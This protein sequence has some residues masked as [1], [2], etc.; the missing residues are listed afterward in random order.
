[1]KSISIPF[2]FESASGVVAT[3]SSRGKTQATIDNGVIAKQ[4]IADVL[5]TRKNERVMR[6][7]YGGGISNLLF[8]PLD[9]LVFADYRIDT[10]SDINRNVSNAY[11][12]DVQIRQANTVQY[13]D[14]NDSTLS[15]RVVY[16][17]AGYGTTTYSF[18]VNSNALLT[19]E[20]PI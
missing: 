15:V 10:L 14:T 7:E 20:S 18:T 1:M 12:R 5:A 17:V 16:D 8:E 3:S 2:R 13:N 19:E 9:P 11:I 4:K 6:P